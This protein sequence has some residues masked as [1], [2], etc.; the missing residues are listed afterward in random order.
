MIRTI[1]MS[2]GISMNEYLIYIVSDSIGET[3][4]VLAKAA[5]S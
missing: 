4:E 5:I 2:A 1:T 3:A